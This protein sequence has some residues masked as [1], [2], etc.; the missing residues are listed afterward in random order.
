MDCL[1]EA[2]EKFKLV[3]GRE[4][5]VEILEYSQD[6]IV[7]W[8][9]GNMCYTCGAVDYFDDFASMY[10]D[11]AGEEWGVESYEQNPDGTYAVVLRPKKLLRN[12]K[13][14][15]KIIINGE[16]LSYFVEG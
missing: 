15:V 11:C 3:F 5:L 1:K 2:V 16:E 10:S 13:R 12:R 8:F 7:A 14:H 6:K 9:G 4:A